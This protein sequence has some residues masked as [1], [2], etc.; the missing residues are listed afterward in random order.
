[1]WKR[2]IVIFLFFCYNFF[3]GDTMDMYEIK[4][5]VD[6]IKHG[7]YTFFLLPNIY[8]SVSYKLN[9]NEYNLYYPYPDAGVFDLNIRG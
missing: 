9:K 2:N 1:M 7:G 5:N 8:K 3:D 4:K 6:K